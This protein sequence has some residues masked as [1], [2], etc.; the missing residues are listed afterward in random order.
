MFDEHENAIR[1]KWDPRTGTGY[2]LRLE[3]VG[4]TAGET[5]SGHHRYHVED[6]THHVVTDEWDCP[7]LDEALRVLHGLFE[8]DVMQERHRLEARLPKPVRQEA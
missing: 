8:L 5:P 6:W 7:S 4:A 3:P 2:R 1:Y